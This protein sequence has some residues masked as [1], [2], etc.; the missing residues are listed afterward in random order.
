L[1]IDGFSRGLANGF[2]A[3]VNSIH[4]FWLGYFSHPACDRV[5]YR[6]VR[7]LKIR[8]ILEIGIGDLR[9]SLRMIR[10]A[11]RYR[12]PGDVRYIGIDLFEAACNAGERPAAISLKQAYRQLRSTG[13]RVHLI[14]GDAI[15]SLVRMANA[16]PGNE[17]VVVAAKDVVERMGD[18]WQYIPRMLAPTA[19]VYSRDMAG[20][21]PLLRKLLPNELLSLGSA[22]AQRRAA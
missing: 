21:K 2:W 20:K 8:R 14:P 12:A 9:R 22:A 10:L 13:A 19:L 16:L 6:A 7:R 18:A 11:Q 15:H 5:L 17:L 4:S 3:A 1:D